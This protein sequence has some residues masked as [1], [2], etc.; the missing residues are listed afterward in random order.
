MEY[1]SHGNSV[2]GDKGKESCKECLEEDADEELDVHLLEARNQ[3]TQE[4]PTS[5]TSETSGHIVQTSF[6]RV[7]G[8]H[9]A[10]LGRDKVDE[11]EV[12]E[13]RDE[14]ED[15]QNGVLAHVAKE[16]LWKQ[17][18]LCMATEVV[19]EG[20]DEEQRSQDKG[21]QNRSR[22][23]WIA[24]S[25]PAKAQEEESQTCSVEE[26]PDVIQLSQHLGSS[27][28][29]QWLGRRDVEDEGT[30]ER[31]DSGDDAQIEHLHGT[32]SAV[33]HNE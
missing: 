3:R 8:K 10:D 25:A 6:D 2:G 9:V 5:C 27:P 16:T 32:D 11:G 13:A 4:D 12:H 1:Q 24:H 20:C 19:E 31:D 17:W 14:D 23:P 15:E 7:G 28:V 21:H 30:D 22:L 29:R 26:D 18:S 33:I